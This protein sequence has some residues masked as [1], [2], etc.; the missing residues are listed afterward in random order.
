MHIRRL[1]RRGVLNAIDLF[2]VALKEE[3]EIESKRLVASESLV[4][5]ESFRGNGDRDGYVRAR[6]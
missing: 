1:S 5:N 3:R 6:I 4:D 2:P